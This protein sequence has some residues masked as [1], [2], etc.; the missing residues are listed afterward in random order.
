MP[1][2]VAVTTPSD[3]EIRVTRDFAAPAQA[4]FDFHTKPEH[5]QKWLL[6]PPGW[7]MPVC[8]IDLRAGGTYRY[9]WRNDENGNEFGVHGRFQEITAP[10]RLVHTESMDGRPGEAFCTMTLTQNGGRTT[11]ELTMRFDSKDERDAA[12]E[13]G[14]TEGMSMSYDRLDES[15]S[16]ENVQ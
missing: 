5:V 7:S 3:R 12:L 2:R 6:G 11:L 14:M 4:V 8:E 1:S 13:S 15:M 16:E 9:V 10:S